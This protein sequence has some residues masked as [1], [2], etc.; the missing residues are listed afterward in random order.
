MGQIW[1][2]L[3]TNSKKLALIIKY[4]HF[5]ASMLAVFLQEQQQS[6]KTV[7]QINRLKRRCIWNIKV[8]PCNFSP[9]LLICFC[10][11]WS[12]P[13]RVEL[14]FCSAA[15][16]W[17]TCLSVCRHSQTPQINTVTSMAVACTYQ[18]KHILYRNV[19]ID[20]YDF[21]SIIFLH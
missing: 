21:I 11:N 20:S 17:L 12:V 15:I 2:Q 13:P 9:F 3:M 16:G 1:V 7:W 14:S 18:R 10:I 19:Y 8:S 4:Y 5:S 6:G